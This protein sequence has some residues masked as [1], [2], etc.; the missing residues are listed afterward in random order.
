M[1]WRQTPS[2][3]IGRPSGEEFDMRVFGALTAAMLLIGPMAPIAEAAEAKFTR[4]QYQ[5]E[6]ATL[7]THLK[8]GAFDLNAYVSK[9]ELDRFYAQ[10][11]AER[12]PQTLT[13]FEI[14]VRLQ[15]LAAAAHQ[16]HARVLGISADWSAYQKGGGRAF[17]LTIR[18]VGARVYVA[19]NLS[20]V[21]G[22]RPGDEILSLDGVPMAVWLRRTARDVSAESPY[23]AGS[24]LEYDFPE[25]LWIEAGERPSFRL[26]LRSQ[27]GAP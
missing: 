12:G 1:I 11:R 8:A 17:P 22:V 23:M 4:A 18:I 20:G 5:A 15:R 26:T 24:I 7:Y 19:S 2:P 6:L 25:Y 13:R 10:L 27:G 3:I 9:A 21:A 16:G 14:E